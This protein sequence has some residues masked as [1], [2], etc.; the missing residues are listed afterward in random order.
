MKFKW[1]LVI[2]ITTMLLIMLLVVGTAAYMG[3]NKVI[4]RN[5]DTELNNGSSLGSSLLEAY[6]PGEWSID[7]DKLLKGS[8]IMN[9]DITV[10]DT[11]KTKTGILSTIFLN[12]TRITTS[13]TDDQGKR[14]VGTKANPE[15]IE[16]VITKGENFQGETTING[17]LYKTL[18]T[19]IKDV[20]GKVLGMWFVGIEYRTLQEMLNSV[21]SMILLLG[22]ALLIL[23]S[24]YAN[25]I[26][27]STVRPLK[28]LMND[29]Q[30]I[31]SGDF[32]VPVFG[33]YLVRKDEIGGI[34]KSV[35]NMRQ[36]V[37][38]IILSILKETNSIE[39]AIENTVGEV[40]RL[41]S[42]IEDVSTTTQQLAAGMEETAAGAEEMNATSH[43]ISD[44]IE[45]VADKAGNGML[46]ANEIKLRAEN[47]RA[48]AEESRKSAHTVYN[49]TNASLT[50]SIEKAKSIEQIQQLTD[51]ILAISTQTN[52]L[53]LNAA[54]EAARAGESGKGFAVVADE[55]RKL[56]E[57]SKNA[58]SQIQNVVKEVTESVESMVN[59][60]YD[61]LKFV[62]G[63]VIEDYNTLVKTGEQY[64]TDADYVNGLMEGFTTTSNHLHI[65]I[66]NMLKAIEEITAAAN[67]GA[68]GATN[69]AERSG[70]IIE[71]ANDVVT[72]A[73]QTSQSSHDLN[74]KVSQFKV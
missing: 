63:Q 66:E 24:I 33:K 37:K 42:D 23:G 69:I 46:A 73:K 13:I 25:V 22:A 68:S 10:V 74:S 53:A 51:A 2:S 71:K 19:P 21:L 28:R 44:A 18:Y 29:I 49:K 57:D 72:F 41:H 70:S 54:I 61:I 38:D 4:N 43:E 64:S 11:I 50:Q 14:L 31:S 35:E 3:I 6:Y 8:A 60:S 58:V 47:L 34:S 32:T 62:D 26:G 65:S 56:A 59:D 52:L 55:I 7:G 20:N 1:K 9:D 30:V 36:S 39:G 16:R 48:N 27:A 17:N 67:E 45:D 5:I 40:D 12:D 15:V